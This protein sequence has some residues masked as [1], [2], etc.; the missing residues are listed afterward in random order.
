MMVAQTAVEQHNQGLQREQDEMAVMESIMRDQ[1]AVSSPP[2]E[3]HP[4]E[5]LVLVGTLQ[6]EDKSVDRKKRFFLLLGSVILFIIVGVSVGIG[7]LGSKSDTKQ[8]VEVDDEST[9]ERIW[10]SEQRSIDLRV[11]LNQVSDPVAFIDRKSPQSQALDWLIFEDSL[12]ES[13]SDYNILQRYALTVLAF[14]TNVDIWRGIEAWYKLPDKHECTFVGVDCNAD[15]EVTGISLSIRRLTGRLPDEIGLLTTLTSLEMSRNSLE[16]KI[17]A[18]VFEKL[19][20]L[21]TFQT[22]DARAC[23]YFTRIT[24]PHSFSLL[25]LFIIEIFDI[26]DNQFTGTLPED[27]GGLTD[28][29]E[30]LVSETYLSGSLPESL[31]NWNHMREYMVASAGEV[32]LHSMILD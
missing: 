18:S 19:T 22:S 30:F 16:G 27:I 29:K 11:I 15:Y 3:T 13:A 2:Q 7:V 32:A 24:L 5:A 14:A 23:I 10:D 20:K 1:E 31:S 6:D 28:L 17:P 4:P 25:S 21:G 26:A 12:L 8:E 9:P